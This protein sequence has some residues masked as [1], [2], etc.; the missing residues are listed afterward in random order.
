M[1]NKLLQ[2]VFSAALAAF[3]V[4]F[5]V[6]AVPLTVLI[7]M[8]IIDYITGMAAAY[9]KAE[10]SSKRGLQGIIKKIS[11]M[12]LVAAAMG[13]DYLIYH[14]LSQI[15]IYQDSTIFFGLLITFWLVINELIS[16]LENLVKLDVPVPKFLI[17][18]IE[19][20]K[21][22]IEKKGE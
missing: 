21:I 10:L 11:Y 9:I 12:A 16:I 4:Y 20:L 3:S 15:G 7:I 2:A 18:I 13:L 17:K 5:N 14:G 6:I 1:D 19:K 22:A 8:M